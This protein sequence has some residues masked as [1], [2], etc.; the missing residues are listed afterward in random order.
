MSH[1]TG[2][3]QV[4]DYFELPY[5]SQMYEMY[6]LTAVDRVGTSTTMGASAKKEE[7]GKNYFCFKNPE[8]C[9][10]MEIGLQHVIALT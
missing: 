8:F 5:C 10:C 9:M 6:R 4:R 1:V 7:L 2:W 3:P